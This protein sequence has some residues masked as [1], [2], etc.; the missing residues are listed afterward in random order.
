M[1]DQ[2]DNSLKKYN[3]FYDIYTKNTN[4]SDLIDE[5]FDTIDK[6]YRSDKYYDDEFID[7][8]GVIKKKISKL[9]I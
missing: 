8:Y 7:I 9:F 5:Q 2:I 3:N 4:Y 1:K 6:Y